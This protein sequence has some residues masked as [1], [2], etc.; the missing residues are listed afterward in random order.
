MSLSPNIVT[1]THTINISTDPRVII[2]FYIKVSKMLYLKAV[3]TAL[4]MV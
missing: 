1:I 3:E 4:L 2:H